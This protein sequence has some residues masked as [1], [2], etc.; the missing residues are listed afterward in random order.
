MSNLTLHIQFDNPC[1]Y[2]QDC[3]ARKLAKRKIR[4]NYLLK[5]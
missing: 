4:C 2:R 1:F 5:L 3:R